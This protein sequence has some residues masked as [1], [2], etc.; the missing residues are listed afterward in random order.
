MFRKI[1]RAKLGDQPTSYFAK[2]TPHHAARTY[3]VE[4]DGPILLLPGVSCAGNYRV[5]V[6]AAFMPHPLPTSD[7]YEKLS[8]D[9]EPPASTTSGFY[10]NVSSVCTVVQNESFIAAVLNILC[11][12]LGSMNFARCFTLT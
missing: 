10:V 6:H 11:T 5:C 1:L 7:C 4:S 3:H 12:N 2:K 9:D 8:I